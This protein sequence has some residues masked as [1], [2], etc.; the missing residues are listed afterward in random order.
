ML[1][2]Y[3]GS[4]VEVTSENAWAHAYRLLLWIDRS[5]GLAHCYE[6]DK[7]QPGRPWYA[8]SLA[9]HAWVA[10]ALGTTPNELGGRIDWLFREGT[11]L[12]AQAIVAQT[13]ARTQKADVQRS[14]FA[15]QGMPEPGQD[16]E[17]ELLIRDALAP[18]LSSTPP[19]EALR[20]LTERIRTYLNQENKR[21][22]LVGEGFEDV[23]AFIMARLPGAEKFRV[24][25]RPFLHEVPGFH[26]PAV[27]QK[28]RRVDLAVLLP[29][30]RRVLLTAKWSVRA[31]REEQFGV[32]YETYSRLENL[33][34]TFDF[35]LL[36]NEFDAARLVA[37]CRRRVANADLFSRVVHVNPEGPMAA[38]GPELRRSARE[39]PEELAR[40]RLVS[41]EKWLQ[42]L[43]TEA[44]QN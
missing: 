41:L 16:P 24:M 20:A 4:G 7:A 17:L 33:G 36:T 21:K 10:K 43:L 5:T 44:S 19:P 25:I 14:G 38:Y 13:A 31:D 37:A 27:G 34:E 11:A 6:S 22:N 23:L 35:V 39:L 30:G 26:K 29:S 18:W 8:R 3:F 40:G 9:F 15:G 2:R 28:P 42:E 1:E 12:M 32:D